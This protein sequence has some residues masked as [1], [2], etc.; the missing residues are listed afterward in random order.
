MVALTAGCG[1]DANGGFTVDADRSGEPGV[2]RILT[3]ASGVPA[4]GNWAQI[5]P[6]PI[7]PEANDWQ[8]GLGPNAGRVNDIA[9]DPTSPTDQILYVATDG[10]IWKSVDGG[11]TWQP[12]TDRMAS[13]AP[14]RVLLDPGD[15][16]TIYAPIPNVGLYKSIDGGETWSIPS[17][18]FAGKAVEDVMVPAAG[19]IVF[20]TDIGIYKSID[21]GAHFGQPPSF[22]DN[23]PVNGGLFYR[24][25]PDAAA[26]A[27]TWLATL[28]NRG[29]LARSTDGGVT[30]G[31][32]LFRADNGGLDPGS[33]QA[34]SF[35][36]AAPPN[37]RILYVDAWTQDANMVLT[38]RL[39]VS[40]DG[41]TNWAPRA[42]SNL[43]VIVN[44]GSAWP[45]LAVDPIVPTR[46]YLAALDLYRSLDGGQTFQG[47]G[48]GKIHVDQ[49]AFV[50]SPHA[51]QGSMSS[52]RFYSGN[53]G[54]IF[55]S[56]TAGVTFDSH[57]GNLA[58]AKIYEIDIGRGSALNNT[59]SWIA[60]QDNGVAAHVPT[61]GANTWQQLYSGDGEAVAIAPSDPEL[62]YF[63]TDGYTQVRNPGGTTSPPMLLAPNGTSSALPSVLHWAIDAH[64]ENIVHALDQLQPKLYLTTA[65]QSRFLLV[66]T[67][68]SLPTAIA[69]DPSHS[70]NVWL[71]FADG[72][73][74]R[75]K[76]ATAGAGAGWTTFSAGLPLPASVAALAVDPGNS[77]RVVAVY[78]DLSNITNP[79]LRTRHVFMTETGGSAWSDIGGT[80]GGPP[81]ANVPDLYVSSVV[82]DSDP[83]LK[84]PRSIIIANMAGVLET[85]DLGHSW[86]RL[87]IGLPANDTYSN[88]ALDSS[89]SPSTLRV[90]AVGRG[91]FE[92]RSSPNPLLMVESNLA[93]GQQAV[94]AVAT[95][96]ARLYNASL[97]MIVLNSVRPVSASADF[98]V[99]APALPLRLVPGAEVDLVMQ[100]SP[101]TR[102]NQRA[103]FRILGDGAN[104]LL[105]A[106]GT[107][108]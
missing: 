20:A 3:A 75:T 104:A 82:I 80:D 10:G 23:Q 9:V 91:C 46:V 69:L 90:C 84:T 78:S 43:P 48:T 22:D 53:D 107:G 35:A 41:G 97:Q 42:A 85:R 67:F 14:T 32:N 70:D 96:T 81:S 34:I 66:H 8:L 30:F 79:S 60:M 12:K 5:G 99:K 7:L 98:Q 24:L 94:G 64:N 28:S 100:F 76:N 47:V 83:S 54:G 29:G 71:G 2:S 103:S 26:P 16:S 36:Q 45:I 68:P 19:T 108:N 101:S 72:T 73:I 37:Q 93:F 55:S 6:G 51:P 21:G 27:T 59:L 106:S 61:S 95:Q 39:F 4:I 17:V 15:P 74:A 44:S 25:R 18:P 49:R 58:S 92:L 86:H 1:G 57:N 11:V 56:N 105:F 13:L 31:S 40:N 87:G 50:F 38:T 65:G 89:V 102:G 88:L 52:W 62:V 33:Y 77:E 63:T